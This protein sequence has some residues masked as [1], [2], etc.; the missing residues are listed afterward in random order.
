MLQAT[1]S[2]DMERASVTIVPE[3]ASSSAPTTGSS[4]LLPT[5]H[6]RGRRRVPCSH[7]AGP[8]CLGSDGTDG[9]RRAPSLP[10]MSLFAT[11]GLR[12]ELAR[13]NTLPSRRRR[14]RCWFTWEFHLIP[15][16]PFPRAPLCLRPSLLVHAR[17]CWDPRR[18]R[19]LFR[20]DGL[21]WMECG[22]GDGRSS[23]IATDD[24]LQVSPKPWSPHCSAYL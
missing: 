13:E 16:F 6:V 9:S 15:C 23:V 8:P 12:A 4:A 3:M 10:V 11:P 19:A 20:S 22:C 21:S 7:R 14:S 18:R 24:G 5:Y 17:N 1:R 2:T